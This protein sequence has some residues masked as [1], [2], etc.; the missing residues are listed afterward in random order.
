MGNIRNVVLMHGGFVDGFGWQ[1]VYDLLKADG[2][3]VT[4]VQNPTISLEGDA[5]ATKIV[6]DAQ[7]GP[8]VLVG[9]SYGGAVITVAGTHD[10]VPALVYISAFAPD[11]EESVNTLISGLPTEGPLP[12]ILPPKDGFLFLDREK[13]A[14]SFAGDLPEKQAAKNADR[15]PRATGE[16]VRGTVGSQG[17][18]VGFWHQ[19]GQ[20]RGDWWP[21]RAGTGS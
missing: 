12:P 4:I 9:H 17:N 14:E 7:D 8:A 15:D 6:L 16:N 3:R 21:T 20:A 10:K 11:K 5:A 2:F 1:G 19:A 18:L 13:F